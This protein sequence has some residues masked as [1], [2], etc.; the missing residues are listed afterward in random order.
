MSPAARDT[1]LVHGIWNARAWLWPFA[2]RL[3]A[4]GLRP[5]IFGYDSVLDTPARAAERLAEALRARP[6]PY[7]VGHSLGGLVL[8]EALRLAPDLAV[9]RAVCIG[10]PLLGSA[11]AR[12]LSALPGGGLLLGASARTLLEGAAPWDG[13]VAVGCIAGDRAR[14]LGGLFVR[15]DTPSDGTVSVEETRLPGIAAHCV[16]PAS[17]TGLVLSD[18]A[19][20]QAARFL[21]E[22]RFDA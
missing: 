16:V 8:L 12:K 11:A 3:R 10:S 9:E 14:G 15:F 13:P 1:L 6:V 5:D 4:H 22:G 21:R 17:H 2:S 7:L 20:A 19:A 18:H